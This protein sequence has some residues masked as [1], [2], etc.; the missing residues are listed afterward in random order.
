VKREISL[1]RKTCI[2]PNVPVYLMFAKIPLKSNSFWQIWVERGHELAR[3]TV[4]G[5]PNE[6]IAE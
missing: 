4:L 5:E 6:A 3:Y 2:S 1:K